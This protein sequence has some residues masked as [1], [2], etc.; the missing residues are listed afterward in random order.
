MYLELL[1]SEHPVEAVPTEYVMPNRELL[2]VDQEV[3]L[4]ALD[5]KDLLLRVLW[6]LFVWLNLSILLKLSCSE[7]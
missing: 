7:S 4:G 2:L 5:A 6:L 3:L 1:T